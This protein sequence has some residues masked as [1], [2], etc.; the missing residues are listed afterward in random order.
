MW[1]I[2]RNGGVANGIGVTV[3]GLTLSGTA[4]TNY[5]LTQ[6]VGLTANITAVGVTITSG[7]TAN[8]KVYD[9]T[10]IATISSNNVVLS[11]V[12]PGDVANVRLNTNGYVANF[13]NGGVANG[14]GVTVSGLTLSGASATNYTLTQPVGLTANITAV[15]VTISAGL[16]ADNKVYDGTTSATISSNNVVLSG[17]LPGDVANVRLTT[18]GY[19]ANFGNG[20]VAN[21]IGVT[22][23]G[24]TLSGTAATN[25]TL[26]QPV[27]LTAN[28]T[29]VGVT[30][31]AGLSADNKVYD[32]TTSATISSNNVVLSGVLPG[33]VANVRLNTN[34][35]VAN[36][37]QRRSG[38][39]DWSNGKRIDVERHGCNELHVDA[40]GWLD[41][42]HHGSRRDDQRWVEC[43]QQGV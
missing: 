10:T 35:Y 39:W 29:A 3:S 32:G 26:M 22:V 25:Y 37:A 15:G 28:I 16:S 41:S 31:S 18:N 43:G 30:I 34:G 19:V 21:G 40:A 2:S 42:Q 7:I 23:S 11:G 6:P 13:G 1:R 12:L 24:L 20:G 17:V 9:G 4:A 8:N 36:F 14:I 5:T 27:G 38:Q 33:D